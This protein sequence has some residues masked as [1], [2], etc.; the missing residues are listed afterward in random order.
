MKWK[1]CEP[2]P[3]PPLMGFKGKS[4]MGCAIYRDGK[5]LYNEDD[6]KDGDK[7]AVLEGCIEDWI[8]EDN[9]SIA[10]SSNVDSFC[11][12]EFSKDD[13]KCWVAAGFICCCKD[14]LQ[15]EPKL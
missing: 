1:V 8:V 4:Y 2:K 7:I 15:N 9:K 13:R 12:L 5:V 10:R 3:G 11:P 6:I 14:G